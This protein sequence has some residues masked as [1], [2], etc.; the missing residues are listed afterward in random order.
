MYFGINHEVIIGRDLGGLFVNLLVS[1]GIDSKEFHR[2]AG[3]LM[4]CNGFKRVRIEIAGNRNTYPISPGRLVLVGDY[5]GQLV[6]DARQLFGE[7]HQRT[8]LTFNDPAY[9]E[10]LTH[11]MYSAYVIGRRNSG[12]G[13]DRGCLLVVVKKLEE[14]V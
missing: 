6:G 3:S 10:D 14:I 5:D 8:D 1:E 11:P 2:I 12:D 9:H 13:S 7:L 4:N